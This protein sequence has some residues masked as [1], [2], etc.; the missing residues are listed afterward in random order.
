MKI[1]HNI[2]ET[3]KLWKP[4][5]DILGADGKPIVASLNPR[6]RSQRWIKDSLL[7]FGLIG[8]LTGGSI[9]VGEVVRDFSPDRQMPILVT[10]TPDGHAVRVWIRPKHL[11]VFLATAF[12]FTATNT[13]WSIPGSS[14]VTQEECYAGGAGG[15]AQA[16][17][18][19]GDWWGGPGGN[20]AIKTGLSRSSGTIY[21]R[22]API[23]NGSDNNTNQ[24]QDGQQCYCMA[25]NTNPSNVNNPTNGT[26]DCRAFGGSNG[27][28]PSTPGQHNTI[29]VEATVTRFGGNGAVEGG[30]GGGGGGGA[31]GSTGNGN[32]ASGNTG[33]TH[34]TDGN[35]VAGNGGGGTSSTGNVGSNYGGG[36]ASGDPNGNGGGGNGAGGYIIITTITSASAA[37]R[38]LMGV[39]Q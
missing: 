22:V 10:D 1:R 18:Q 5:T 2:F 36:G 30:L 8:C 26:P 33:G 7:R 28:D 11:P 34:G 14:T 38:T 19:S 39:G 20:Y 4:S 31:S 3:V 21:A 29:T 37:T 23:A 27:D 16:T 15:G 6:S 13:A 35:A 9:Q 25:P 32:N 17:N 24:A 12:T